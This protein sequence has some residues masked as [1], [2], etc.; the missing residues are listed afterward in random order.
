MLRMDG[1]FGF[2]NGLLLSCGCRASFLELI[3]CKL[4]EFRPIKS[5]DRMVAL[6]DVLTDLGAISRPPSMFIP[7]VVAASP[8]CMRPCTIPA[9]RAKKTHN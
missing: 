9:F 2:S 5:F 6:K 3:L 8:Q 7:A 4:K 1:S